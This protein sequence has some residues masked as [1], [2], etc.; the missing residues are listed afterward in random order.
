MSECASHIKLL[1]LR[2]KAAG[3]LLEGRTWWVLEGVGGGQ[4]TELISNADRFFMHTDFYFL[5]FGANFFVTCASIRGR[6]RTT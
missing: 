4:L 5:C 6:A 2:L 3:F 1:S